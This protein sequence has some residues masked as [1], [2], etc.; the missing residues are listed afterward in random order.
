MDMLNIQAPPPKAGPWMKL[1]MKITA[2]NEV[3]LRL[4]PSIDWDNVRAIGEIQ[5]CVWLFQTGLFSLIGHRLAAA[6]QIRPEI[7]IIAM[8][9]ATMI[10][11]IDSYVIMRSGW[12]IEGLKRLAQGGLD[13]SG[14][15]LARIKAWFF[16][17]VRIALSIGLA[18]L[19]AIFISI[20]V[21][22]ADINA[23]IQDAYLKANAHL[24]GPATELVDG[25]IQRDTDAVN[26]QT[27]LA[28]E[29]GAQVATLRQTEIDGSA[30]DPQIVAAGQEVAQ[31]VTRKAAADDAVVAAQ[32]FEDNEFG[33][34]KGD[35]E[36]S[37]KPGYGLRYLAATQKVTAAKKYAAEIAQQL[38]A[39]RD[40]LVA[41]RGQLPSGDDAA[42][43]RAHEQLPAFE[44]TLAAESDKLTNLKDELTKLTAGRDQAIRDAIENAPDHVPL[45]NG[46]LAQLKVLKQIAKQDNGIA[47]VILLIDV[48][49]F[50]FELAAVLS[51]ITAFVPT[52]YAAILARDAY[53]TAVKIVDD[54]M[55]EL[56]DTGGKAPNGSAPPN[57]PQTPND[58]AP[59][60]L[61]RGR[62][63]PRK[64]PLPVPVTGANG[65][66]DLGPGSGQPAPA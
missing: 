63:R 65:R 11:A 51:K 7:V 36:N 47:A 20:L 16:L 15:A 50:G 64:H 38:K 18:Q 60:P 23:P 24:L 4:C 44:N 14:S 19:S 37:G 54:M 30:S 52:T 1:L 5:I 58:P 33:G 31:L 45:D 32:N 34:I 9:L 10:T 25:E 49:A 42:R 22:Q 13:I 29:L 27:K 35:S 28:N 56:E 59:Q 26:A 39:A 48:I 2:V 8:F 66:E 55:I 53:M 62:G 17:T 61:K 40:Q 41:V 3:I 12:H 46:F 57:P 6:Q 21:Y 43:Q